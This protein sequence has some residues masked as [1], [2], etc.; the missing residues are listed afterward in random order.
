ML[1]NTYTPSGQKISQQLEVDGKISTRRDYA[2]SFVYVNN[3][4]AWV[5]IP[6]GRMVNKT[7]GG[8]EMEEY[9]LE[10][11]LRDHL[12]NTRATYQGGNLTSQ[13]DYYPFG[14]TFY[15]GASQGTSTLTQNRYL[16][17]GK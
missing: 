11:H 3:E 16:Y 7:H 1:H 13:T 6:H 12:G 8:K 4:L 2:G 15:D 9:V 14:L 17:N 5:N 10:Y